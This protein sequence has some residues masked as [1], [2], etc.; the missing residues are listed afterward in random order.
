VDRPIVISLALAAILI[1]AVVV[2]VF[3]LRAPAE[4]EPEPAPEP[5]PVEAEVIPAEPEAGPVSIDLAPLDESDAL[6]RLLAQELS[7]HPRLATTLATDELVRKF[8]AAM[9]NIAAGE[10]PSAHLGVLA[11]EGEFHAITRNGRLVV[12]P[13]SYRRYDWLADAFG[14]LNTEATVQ[15]YY[16]L[17]PLLVEAYRDLGYPEGDFH[18][19][20][21]A[22][23]DEL[24]ATPVIQG[25]IE[26]EPSV[27]S[28]RYRDPDIE[29]LSDV[30][31][32]M[33]RMGPENV[34]EIQ[35]K[36]RELRMAL[37]VPR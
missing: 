7:A 8:V 31:K 6:V 24:V 33:L 32:H 10:T 4:P 34:A 16:Q 20:L 26:L 37:A 2:Y 11:P 18:D 23:I 13:A 15:L 21:L 27:L 17:K 5:E 12:D 1:V 35:G 30:D 22:A 14:S 29:S 25:D 28:Y 36:L 19:V 9:V 3:F